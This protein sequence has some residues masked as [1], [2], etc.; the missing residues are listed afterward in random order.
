MGSPSQTGKVILITGGAR[1][2]GR[3]C[4][5]RFADVGARVALT[6]L[7]SASEAEE[8]LKM[9]NGDGHKMFRA[10]LADPAQCRTLVSDVIRAYSR[11][12]VL[13]NNAGVYIPHP[14][15]GNTYENWLRAWDQ[16]M[17][18]N[19]FSAANM[20]FLAAQQMIGQGSGRI[21]NIS[22]RG[23]FRGE[24]DY[25]AYGAS[26][27]GMNSMSQ[28]LAVALA[29]Y[30]IFVGVVA[31]GFV[32]T[33]MSRELLEGEQGR[34]IRAQSPLSRAASPEEIAEAVFLMATGPEYMTGAIL[35][36]NGASYLRS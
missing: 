11:I 15:P 23:A 18:A 29:P 26:K 2:I 9:L 22:S 27:A 10:D 6:Y 13:V 17:G 19:L 34:I 35:D 14:V 30:G 33:D 32:E 21:I 20:S 31:P 5:V 16:T 28:S 24:P 36:V 7:T 12:D 8:T 3:A 25:P 4:A 1:G